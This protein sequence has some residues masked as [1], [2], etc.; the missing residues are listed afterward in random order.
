MDYLL[1]AVEEA[2]K[3]S[4][5][6]FEHGFAAA[7]V[8]TVLS[9]ATLALFVRCQA[10]EETRSSPR[11]NIQNVIRANN[12][13]L[14]MVETEESRLDAAWTANAV[15]AFIFLVSIPFIFFLSW[16]F[17][18]KAVTFFYVFDVL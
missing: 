2:A 6:L 12:N 11:I 1:F 18:D 13:I 4:E 9:S 5:P 7:V 14:N 17:F 3:E 15:A 8:F 10:Y 16:Y